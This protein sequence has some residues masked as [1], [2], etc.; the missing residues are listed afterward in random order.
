VAITTAVTTASSISWTILDTDASNSNKFF[1][2]KGVFSYAKNY[3][4]GTGILGGVNTVW[5]SRLSI[6]GAVKKQVLDLQSLTTTVF[7]KS[8]T[9]S[10]TGVKDVFI[11]N[12]STGLGYSANVHA[13][14]AAG[15]TNVFGG[16]SG[17]ITI[18]PSSFLHLNSYV[19]GWPVTNVNRELTINSNLGS[20]LSVNVCFAGTSG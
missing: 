7:G 20:G 5:H 4:D 3:I 6:T 1:E 19:S 15:W 11:Q 12:A 17:N 18:N 8:F 13:T 10:F 9:E 14:G 2:D 16:E